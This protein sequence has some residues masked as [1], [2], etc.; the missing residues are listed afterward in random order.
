MVLE[1]YISVIFLLAVFVL[2]YLVSRELGIDNDWRYMLLLFFFGCV[3]LYLA[4]VVD[5]LTMGAGL[6]AGAIVIYLATQA[7]GDDQI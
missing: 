6:F 1:Q 2:I 3:G 5:G 4:G 7:G